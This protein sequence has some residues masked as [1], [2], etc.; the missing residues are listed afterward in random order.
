MRRIGL[1][2]VLTLSLML[3]PVAGEAQQA[4]KFPRIG[5]LVLNLAGARH[6]TEAFLQGLVL[7]PAS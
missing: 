6:L 2:V 3:A 7:T 5:Y 1:A 4:A